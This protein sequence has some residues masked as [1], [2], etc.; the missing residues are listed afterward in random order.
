[1]KSNQCYYSAFSAI[2]SFL[3][4]PF[5]FS[6]QPL[7]ADELDLKAGY[8]QS[9]LSGSDNL[10]P[11]VVELVEAILSFP[12][13]SYILAFDPDDSMPLRVVCDQQEAIGPSLLLAVDLGYVVDAVWSLS[14]WLAMLEIHISEAGSCSVAFSVLP[15]SGSATG[16]ALEAGQAFWLTA[17]P[18]K[19]LSNLDPYSIILL[20]FVPGFQGLT[21]EAETRGRLSPLHVL[22]AVRASLSSLELSYNENAVKALYAGA[23]LIDGSVGLAPW[24]ELGMPAIRL[25]GQLDDRL[26]YLPASMQQYQEIHGT[27]WSIIRDVNY[28]RYQLAAAIISL[29]DSTV[30]RFILL[31]LG[32][33]MASVALRPLFTRRYTGGAGPGA[34]PEALV[35]YL[36]S[37]IAVSF[38]WLTHGFAARLFGSGYLTVD[39]PPVYLAIGIIGKLGS[40][41]LFFFAISG[42]SARLGLLPHAVR[43]TASQASAMIAGVLGMS[44]LF[45]SIQGSLLLFGAMILLSLAGINAAVAI[46]SVSVLLIILFPLVFSAVPVFIPGLVTIL[47]AQGQQLLLLAGFIA[48]AVLWI[49]TTLSPRHRLVRGDRTAPYL[50]AMAV[51][52]CFLDPWLRA[53]L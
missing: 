35:A 46:L 31:L 40:T 29:D 52:L 13:S 5:L 50:V 21:L 48:P 1:M 36:F 27:N 8:Y 53:G 7:K 3:L 47:N 16:S 23:G 6:I 49:L 51:A 25:Y 19:S 28:L 20:D 2:T 9:V 4:I 14:V 42:L 30:T 45:L 34:M 15:P 11:G 37:F 26:Q 32:G 24:L 12:G 43:G 44:V 18:Y 33:F 17:D 22:E 38:S 10:L 41:M 39:L